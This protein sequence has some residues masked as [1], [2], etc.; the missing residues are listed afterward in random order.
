MV[1]LLVKD[2]LERGGVAVEFDDVSLYSGWV[3]SF[4]DIEPNRPLLVLM[5]DIDT[6]IHQQGDKEISNVLDGVT[7][8]NKVVYLAT[9][10][11]LDK[12]HDK[13]KKRPSRFDQIIEVTAPGDEDR[14]IYLDTKIKDE[15]KKRIRYDREKWI[16]DTKKMTLS[17]LR[18]LIVS[19]VVIG[20]DYDET[21]TKLKSMTSAALNS[22]TIGFGFR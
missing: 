6:I 2:V 16:R 21:I 19:V 1:S 11:E 22:G 3:K 20:N 17:H 14:G 4:R 5:E 12:L 7:Q 10:N 9:T 18:E 8:S 15:D 13:I